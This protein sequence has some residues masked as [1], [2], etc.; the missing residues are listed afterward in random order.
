MR[1]AVS[2]KQKIP[3]NANAPRNNRGKRNATHAIGP[4]GK[5]Y[6][7]S[8]YVETVGERFVARAAAVV[9]DSGRNCKSTSAV[10]RVRFPR[11]AQ[12]LLAALSRY[13]STLDLA[14][15]NDV[16]A[17]DAITWESFYSFYSK[18]LEQRALKQ[19]TK[20][21][22]ILAINNLLCLLADDNNNISSSSRWHITIAGFPKPIPALD[23][24]YLIWRNRL[25]TYDLSIYV[26]LFGSEFVE[27]SC[28]LIKSIRIDAQIT[29][30]SW[31]E[32]YVNNTLLIFEQLRIFLNVHATK[33]PNQLSDFDSDHWIAFGAHIRDAVLNS[34]Y[35]TFRKSAQLYC[36]NKIFIE[37]AR[38]GIIPV[39]L[40]LPQPAES[41]YAKFG[42]SKYAVSIRNKS[43]KPL[44]PLSPLAF[45]IEGH[46]QTYDYSAYE[47]L[48]PSLLLETVPVLQSFYSN[49][50]SG[51]ASRLHHSLRNFL[52]WL[53]EKKA[54]CDTNAIF[55]A[56]GSNRFRSVSA[57][58][59]ESLVY[60]WRDYLLQ[61][62]PGKKSRT[63]PSSHSIVTTLRQIWKRLAD[64]NIVPPISIRGYKDAKKLAAT[65]PRK[66]L[67]QLPQNTLSASVEAELWGRISRFFGGTSKR[68]AIEFVRS[69]AAELPDGG[70]DISVD[71]LVHMIYALNK[72]RIAQ[73][74]QF[75]ETEF[76]QWH[77]H[78]DVGQQA[79]ADST[80]SSEVLCDLLDSGLRSVHELRKNCSRLLFN[81][82]EKEKLGNCLKYIL[83]PD[84]GG[85]TARLARY[86][87][88]YMQFGGRENF[89]AYLHPHANATVALWII[90]M[91][92][93]AANCEVAR[94][95]P[96]D[97]ISSGSSADSRRIDF[98]PKLRAKGKLIVDELSTKTQPGQTFSAVDAIQLYKKMASRYHSTATDEAKK[99]LLLCNLNGKII[100]LNAYRGLTRFRSLLERHG[101]SWGLQ[102]TPSMLRPSVL[103]AYQRENGDQVTAAQILADHSNAT[104]TNIHYTGRSPLV[105][106]HNLRI[107]EFQ[108]RYQAVVIA[109]ISDAAKKIGL[110][111]E[112]SARI[113]SD[114]ARTGLGVACLDPFAGIQP[115]T[116]AGQQCTRLDSCSDCRM[117]W[118]VATRSNVAD[119]IL[120]HEHLKAAQI[121]QEE[122][123]SSDWENRWLPWLVFSTVAL[124]KLQQGET[125]KVFLEAQ[126]I[127]DSLRSNYVGIP[128]E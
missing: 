87:N 109:S 43:K 30:T 35:E 128:L 105:I 53:S 120:F 57:N 95:M 19:R 65:N 33:L 76:L 104:T 122:K 14:L 40:T 75:A 115:G 127:A 119:L 38:T 12:K 59:W 36:V 21:R 72:N 58:Q 90:L 60:Q 39:R 7:F 42:E 55:D 69:I 2:S 123:G 92:D 85:A 6:D 15:Q 44:P 37:M 48:A 124:A 68:Q 23:S 121:D 74:R 83:C 13:R 81:G 1:D 103:M 22:D 125:A 61:P 4:D 41:K 45:R 111:D 98:G 94:E 67:A 52:R 101:Q 79:I 73:I 110:T 25:Y 29:H 3:Y 84:S 86:P 62:Q 107:R 77:R 5:R 102:A 89:L 26:N 113:F 16:Y 17:F 8:E 78:W 118:V 51:H 100:N 80:T 10:W 114:A 9:G 126:Q 93:T 96:W 64:A 63:L 27:Q 56:I 91:I 106:E 108:D 71:Q 97:C 112:E 50:S 54:E 32:H 47:S 49:W 88:I 24:R 46:I 18:E 20:E 11:A 31:M 70:K 117:R 82:P 116:K 28:T 66:S 34:R 99:V